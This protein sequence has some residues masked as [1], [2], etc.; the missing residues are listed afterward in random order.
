MMQGSS[1]S[2]AAELKIA[3]YWAE[4]VHYHAPPILGLEVTSFITPLPYRKF[5]GGVNPTNWG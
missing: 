3:I 5:I 4:G 2:D 1:S